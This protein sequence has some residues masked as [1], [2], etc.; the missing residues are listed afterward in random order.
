MK[1][2]ATILFLFLYISPGFA[3]DPETKTF[4]ALFKPTELKQNK[5]SLK[6]IE[7]QFSFFSTKTY[8]GNS[9]MALLIVIPSCDFDACFLGEFL[10][11]LGDGRNVQLQQLA[12]RVFDLSENKS[13]HQRYMAMYEESLVQKKKNLKSVKA[14]SLP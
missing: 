11:T 6:S 3:K 5:I 1:K 2:L 4:L 7:A 10:V 13:L 14:A 8:D 9:E 12:F